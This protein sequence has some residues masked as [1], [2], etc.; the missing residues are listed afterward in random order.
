MSKVIV[1]M[2]GGVDSSV[3]AALL[4]QQGFEVEG[5]FMKNWSPETIQSL[6]DCPWEQDL[7]DAEAVCKVLNIPFRSVNFEREY[8]DKVVDY[9]LSEYSAGR[10]PNPDIMCNKEIKFRAFLEEAERLGADFIA[11]GHYVRKVD[12]KLLRGEDKKKDQSYFLYTLDDE[13]LAKSLFP[14]GE[15]PKTEVRHLAESFKLP[16]AAKKDSQ[17]ICF[18][19]HIDLKKF[20]MEQIEASAGMVHLLGHGETLEERKN[21]AQMVGAHQGTMFYTLGEKMG[22]CIDNNLFRQVTGKTDIPHTYLVHV[23]AAENNLYVS[24]SHDDKHLWSTVVYLDGY[25]QTGGTPNGSVQLT[26]DGLVNR[27]LQCQIRYQQKPALV[28]T[29]SL[30]GEKVR[31][32]MAEALWAV[33]PGQ[34]LVLYDGDETVGGGV[35]CATAH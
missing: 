24:D 22:S 1:A 19:G 32:E 3:A 15:L 27:R 13:Q 2:S 7:A 26:V 29:I 12:G 28:S 4:Q 33:T 6:T 23:D 25:V 34:S 31:V 16:T 10:T 8:K 30:E 17:G 21:N 20:L 11:T 9:F 5:I 14:I 18:I 35:I